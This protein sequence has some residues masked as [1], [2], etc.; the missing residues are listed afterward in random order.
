MTTKDLAIRCGVTEQTIRR[1]CAKNNIPKIRNKQSKE[2]YE[3]TEATI[4]KILEVY[5]DVPN[6]SEHSEQDA[7]IEMHEYTIPVLSCSEHSEHSEQSVPNSSEHQSVAEKRLEQYVQQIESQQ[8]M[9]ESLTGQLSVKDGQIDMLNQQLA[10]MTATVTAMQQTQQDL[11]T[12]LAAAQALHAGTIQKQLTMKDEKP[13]GF[14][15]RLFRKK[16]KENDNEI[17]G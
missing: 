6:S 3:L 9:I 1:W 4:A 12:A 14:F 16:K 10:A 7:I 2:H 13:V 15:G 17:Q 11:T 8:K 5:G